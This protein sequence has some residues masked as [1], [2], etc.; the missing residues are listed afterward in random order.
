MNLLPLDFAIEK[1]YPEIVKS[2]IENGAFLNTESRQ[3][4]SIISSPVHIAVEYST[5]EIISILEENG[6]NVAAKRSKR[7]CLR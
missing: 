4:K 6:A 2:L 7:K 3:V 5:P 1:G